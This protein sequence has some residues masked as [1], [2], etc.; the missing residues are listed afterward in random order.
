MLKKASTEVQKQLAKLTG[1]QTAKTNVETDNARTQGKLLQSQIEETNART[2]NI[3]RTT[4]ALPVLS[5]AQ[6]NL[7]GTALVNRAIAEVDAMRVSQEEARSRIR[8]NNAH[9]T[10]QEFDNMGHAM[11]PGNSQYDVFG[12]NRGLFMIRQN[13]PIPMLSN[14]K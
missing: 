11:N 13:W 2:E 4:S 9:A 1:A 5:S 6:A 12:I 3:R 14:L 8:L 10:W 7:L